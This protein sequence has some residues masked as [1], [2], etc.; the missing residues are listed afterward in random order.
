MKYERCSSKS[1]A[2]ASPAHRADAPPPRPARW[3]ALASIAVAPWAVPAQA[4][5]VEAEWAQRVEQLATQAARAALHGRGNVR[6]EVIPGQ[7]DPRLRL[8][9]CQQVDIYLPPGQKAWGPTRVG[10]RCLQGSVRW[11]VYMP[12][13]VRVWAPAVQVQSPV[14]AGTVLDATH[15]QLG[16]ADWAAVDSPALAAPAAA[17]GRTLVRALP[18]G[19]T[20]R[21]A[22][23]KRRQWFAIGDPVRV[24]AS[25]SGFSVSTEGVALTPGF[26]G[27][28]ARVRTEA[29]RT[30]TGT[31]AGDRTLEVSM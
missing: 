19:A 12:L 29:G 1:G 9:P 5:G 30:L 25:G 16:E 14:A 8:A 17:I 3:A 21:E 11:N 24:R 13:T 23:F 31:V 10:L 26:E 27:Q 7:L 4:V 28:S 18:A 6:V 20:L 2:N 15:L 22:D